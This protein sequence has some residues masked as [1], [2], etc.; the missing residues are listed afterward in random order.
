MRAGEGYLAVRG[1]VDAGE[2]EP[3]LTCAEMLIRQQAG[4]PNVSLLRAVLD[5]AAVGMILTTLERGV[6]FV[7]RQFTGLWRLPEEMLSAKSM[8]ELWPLLMAHFAEADA[9]EHRLEAICGAPEE[10]SSDIAELN[11]GRS[12]EVVSHPF[13][14]E[15]R[16][17][18][19]QWMFR[20]VTESQKA[21]RAYQLAKER[22][23]VGLVTEID[24]IFDWNI[25][26]GEVYSSGIDGVRSSDDLGA[27][28]HPDDREKAAEALKRHFETGEAYDVEYRTNLPTGQPYD[29]YMWIRVRGT[30]IR[31]GAGKPVRMV[32]W[33][34]NVTERRNMLEAIEA[35]E[36]RYRKVLDQAREVIFQADRD[37]NLTFLS[38]AWTRCTGRE[39]SGSE[40]RPI[41]EFVLPEDRVVMQKYVARLAAQDQASRDGVEVRW[42]T[43]AGVPRWLRCSMWAEWS[44][45][46]QL[47]GFSGT[48]LDVHERREAEL[49]REKSLRDVEEAQQA[50]AEF[51]A[52]VSHEIRT[53][54]NGIVSACNLLATTVLTGGQAEYL[55]VARTSSNHLLRLIDDLLD[56][57]KIEAGQ[58]D[59][60]AVAF[61]PL[62]LLEETCG[63]FRG[64]MTDRG[65]LFDLLIENPLP[66]LIG[67][68]HRIRQVLGNLLANAAKFTAEG[69]VVVSAAAHGAGQG[70]WRLQFSV[71]DS[72]GGIP[73]EK[74]S[75]I[76]EKFVQLQPGTTRREAGAGL[77]LA[78]SR[79]L[80]LKMGG[81]LSVAS[82][83]DQGSTFTLELTLD[84][85]PRRQPAGQQDA[86]L[87]LACLGD[88]RLSAS[89]GHAAASLGRR[90]AKL[91][92]I[93]GLHPLDC[94][95]AQALLITEP[96]LL[97]S[98]GESGVLDQL[99]AAGLRIAVVIRPGDWNGPLPPGAVIVERPL[100]P[101]TLIASSGSGTPGTARREAEG[102]AP[103]R[104]VFLRPRVLLVE[105][106]E[107]NAFLL[108][109]QLWLAG[110]D[111]D[112]ASSG[113]EALERT[114]AFL[115]DL[116]FMDVE[117]PGMDG[118]ETTR[119]IRRREQAAGAARTRVIALTAHA[120]ELYRERC[121]A[122]GMDDFLAKPVSPAE[123]DQKARNWIDARPVVLVWTGRSDSP[124]WAQALTADP[125]CLTI[126]ARTRDETLRILGRQRVNY[127]VLPV[128]RM[129][130]PREVLEIVRRAAPAICPVAVVSGTAGAGM[131]RWRQMGFTLAVPEDAPLTLD[132]LGHAAM[133]GDLAGRARPARTKGV[134]AA[135]VAA[136]LPGYL[137]NRAAEVPVLLDALAREDFESLRRA[138][139]NM[140]GSGAGYG[141]EQ[142]SEIG[143]EIE[144]AASA[145]SVSLAAAQI[146]RLKA[147]LADLGISIPTAGS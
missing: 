108:N 115:Y 126:P 31:D 84:A 77:G 137:S 35:S 141:L 114:S 2:V 130:N 116:V 74:Q 111:V 142:I 43:E 134:L 73:S 63:T 39:V 61:D 72:G 30:T 66:A 91:S 85:A 4:I 10:D 58:L 7:N 147:E 97:D 101:A 32:G 42:V 52:T 16:L 145:R 146:D 60:D 33:S 136:L 93:R 86:G 38:P 122:A 41:W 8:A 92:R 27:Y 144:A 106:N 23:D 46:G 19:R 18:G 71:A 121:L 53:P 45:G 36:A 26:T 59:V 103:E 79:L 11:D 133:T 124:T 12:I 105:D 102:P 109:E 143:R 57:S 89:V 140:R 55:R 49:A 117:M 15:G 29:G 81:Q 24:G 1:V 113:A 48:I 25:V 28:I 34:T 119:R 9:A 56:I 20:D 44:P 54:L 129:R 64:T 120:L 98:E 128:E 17:I 70:R 132:Q 22:L 118:I 47:N 95:G 65:L 110:Y 50:R 6:L 94:V 99:L 13:R 5:T 88:P 107:D 90:F 83:L 3:L 76:F 75:L 40:G 14:I 123:I 69:G 80:A 104:T 21:L 87:V 127:L 125:R 131:D 112:V 82:E 37:Q 100:L 135:R 138:G 67:D 51:L 96:S 62:A 139:H 78:I 68:P